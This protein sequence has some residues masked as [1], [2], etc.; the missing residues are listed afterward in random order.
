MTGKSTA[1]SK[2]SSRR[3]SSSRSTRRAAEVEPAGRSA[4]FELKPHEVERALSTGEH[5]VLLQRYF[6][7][8]HYA[9]LQE[10]AR[11]AA[12]RSVRGG[13]RVYILPGI[14][15]STLGSPRPSWWNDLIWL[16]PVDISDGK[17]TELAI[18]RNGIKHQALGVILLT[19]LKLK[20]ML[21]IAGYDADFFPYDW[22]LSVE[23]LGKRLAEEIMAAPGDN[24]SLVAHSMGGLVAR[25]ALAK[26]DGKV[27]RLI[28]L[29]TPNHGSFNA[30]QTLRGIYPIVRKLAWFDRK[31]SPE[32]L[33]KDV[34]H[35]FPG[36]YQLLPDPAKFSTFD[37]YD[38]RSWP[39]TGPGLPRADLLKLAKTA[40][41]LYAPPDERFF[42]IAGVNHETIVDVQQ[43]DGDFVYTTSYAGDGTVPVDFAELPGVKTYYAAESH[44][45]LPNNRAVA[46]A[47]ADILGTGTTEALPQQWSLRRAGT[48]TQTEAE[49][50]TSV[51]PPERSIAAGDRDVRHL[52]E[53]LAAPDAH[54][55]I[56]PTLIHDGGYAHRFERIVIGR[57]RQ[58]QLDIRLALGSIT[59]ARN[60]AYVLGIFRD[61]TPTGA[62][63]AV[64]AQLDGAIAEFS[65]RRMFSGNV[66]EVFVLPTGSHPLRADSVLLAGLGPFD[67]FTDEVLEAVAE[68]VIRTFVRTGVEDFATVLLGAGS[69]KDPAMALRHLLAGFLRGLKDADPSHDFRRI[70]VCETDPEQ[71]ARIKT[72]LYR[73]AS[74]DLFGDVEVTLEEVQLPSR[75]D[76]APDMRRLRPV[77][78]APAYLLVR[79]EQAYNGRSEYVSSVLT[80]GSKATVSINRTPVSDDAL[81]RAL[82][83]LTTGNIT[84]AAVEKAG[85]ALGK[86]VLGEDLFHLLGQLKEQ[87]LVVIHDAI[88]SRIP[89]ETLNIQG[90]LPALDCGLSRRY[91]AENLSIAKWL[92]ERRQDETLNIL[93]VV[94]PTGD[95][96][97]AREEGERIRGLLKLLPGFKIQITE[98]REAEA[99]KPVLLED[100]RSGKYDVLHYAGHAFFDPER[101][102][103]SG[104]I[105][106]GGAVLSGADLSG[107]SKLP[108]LILFNACESAKTRSLPNLIE[109]NVGLAEA[110]L[111]GG[112]ANYIGTYWPVDDT[113]AKAFAETFYTRLL[114]G[115]SLGDA[116]L[117]GRRKLREDGS[118]DWADYIL[119]GSPDFVLKEQ[120]T[121]H[122]TSSMAR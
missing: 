30:I 93:L 119:Y 78:E 105:C 8:E 91:L 33:T 37:L 96:D 40:Q 77:E 41:N 87:H 56:I 90:W 68:N 42:L 7:A 61:V 2:Q 21:R 118:P 22:R 23:E 82:A 117:Q 13:P 101:P 44:G 59:E 3:A 81:E 64:D 46:R 47:V 32:Q 86:L 50:R 69:G 72:E 97:G 71:Y 67:R 6:G 84:L 10:L 115:S 28:M 103:R 25:A 98:R 122:E 104:I 116:L 88:T 99:T 65:R 5:P 76:G 43:S 17:L 85:V 107:L 66:G 18:S 49:I 113:A 12:T 57:R 1:V 36:L 9:E 102:A 27:E 35:T 45:R 20:L 39:G 11:T 58:R 19:Y 16:D 53:E 4:P 26:A 75:L 70:T 34:F 108:S 14:M 24:I 52:L 79:H 62:A 110:F 15:G 60:H 51:T 111:R 94:N 55:E 63:Q 92:E 54:E 109:T 38:P 74:T 73:L 29:G 120:R 112:A 106:H 114:E 31:H 89:W 83:P 95:L 80:A 121:R 48:R 100:F